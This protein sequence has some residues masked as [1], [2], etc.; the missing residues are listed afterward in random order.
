MEVRDPPVLTNT[1]GMFIPLTPY[2]VLMGERNEYSRCYGGYINHP[3]LCCFFYLAPLLN[4]W[5][6]GNAQNYITLPEVHTN[7]SSCI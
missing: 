5:I 4:T 2:Q 6:S 1:H 3:R 7:V